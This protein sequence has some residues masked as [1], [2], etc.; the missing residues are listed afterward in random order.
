MLGILTRLFFL[1][2]ERDYGAR[3]EAVASAFSGELAR[4]FFPLATY[5]NNVDL[6]R[7]IQQVV[8]VGPSE[9]AETGQLV[10]AV[11]DRSLPNRILVRLEPNE[12]L[13]DNHPAAGKG[14]L[15]GR[16]AAYVCVGMSCQAPITEPAALAKALVP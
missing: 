12:T 11:L 15:D 13:P 4:N 2:G 10:R 7:S 3:A 1:T 8:I 14:M 6:I 5:L 9:A 16:P